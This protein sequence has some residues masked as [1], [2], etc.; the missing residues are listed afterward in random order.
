MVSQLSIQLARQFKR[1]PLIEASLEATASSSSRVTVL[2]GPSGS[3]K[4]TVLRCVAGLE[5]PDRGRIEVGGQVWFDSGAGVNVPTH[6]RRIGFMHQDYAL[7]PHLSVAKN[8][9]YGLRDLPPA[10]RERRVKDALELCGI[11]ELADR[12]P[13]QISGGQK[14]RVALARALAPRPSILLLDEPLSALDASKRIELRSGLRQLL[15]KLGVP[16]LLVTHDRDEAMVLGDDLAVMLDGKLVQHGSVASV[17]QRP[18]SA[19]IAQVTGV[20]SIIAGRIVKRADGLAYFRP[21]Q[22][23]GRTAG[24]AAMLTGMDSPQLCEGD[25]L[26]LIR[27]EDVAL[28]RPGEDSHGSPRNRLRARVTRLEQQGALIRVSLDAGF[29]LAAA[30]TRQAVEEL[31]L[32]EGIEVLAIVKAP[33]VHLVTR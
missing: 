25:G 31:G 28:S 1:G 15:V 5:T 14:Q 33:A 18:A 22:H 26:A 9:A 17:F 12:K 30:L 13:A 32:R 7:F 27:A 21:L 11:T 16:V 24:E 23:E 20:D 6:K 3:G 19:A 10:E 2:F 4:T 29:D 8:I